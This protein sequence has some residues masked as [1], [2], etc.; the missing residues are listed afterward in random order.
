[1]T[2]SPEDCAAAGSGRDIPSAQAK[3]SDSANEKV[4]HRAFLTRCM[5]TLRDDGNADELKCASLYCA[6]DVTPAKF[7]HKSLFAEATSSLLLLTDDHWSSA[8]GMK[9]C[10]MC[11][12]TCP[13]WPIQ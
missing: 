1:M 10:V 3:E 12:P 13:N 2:G 6:I 5:R 11:Q 4:V 9:E 7:E 8:S